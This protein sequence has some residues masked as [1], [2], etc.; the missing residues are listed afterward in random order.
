MGF[1]ALIPHIL[2]YLDD[3]SLHLAICAVFEIQF[4]PGNVK[5]YNGNYPQYYPKMNYFKCGEKCRSVP[6]CYSL[7]TL[8]IEDTK[9]WSIPRLPNLEVLKMQKS[10]VKRLPHLPNLQEIYCDR[11]KISI[12]L[13]QYPKLKNLNGIKTR[14]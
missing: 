2:K 9:V 3:I 7:K 8:D 13:H 10:R 11:N 6:K 12:N 14:R 5:S 4:D 1:G